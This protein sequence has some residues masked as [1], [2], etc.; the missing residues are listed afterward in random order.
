MGGQR[1]SYR[2]ILALLLVAEAVVIATAGPYLVSLSGLISR[3]LT[4]G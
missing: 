4:G 1:S 2:I 3:S